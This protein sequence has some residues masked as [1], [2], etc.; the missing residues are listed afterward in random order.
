MILIK[1]VLATEYFRMP[2]LYRFDDY[3]KCFGLYESKALYCVVNSFIKPDGKSQLYKFID[4]FSSNRK[5]HLRHDKLQRGIC[6]NS[7]EEIVQ[8]L[9]RNAN[10]YFVEKFP[11]NSKVSESWKL[12]ENIS[13]FSI[14]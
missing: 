2:M 4:K 11:M 6:I 7:C 5:Q 13:L 12:Q 10:N 1:S 14:F 3:E 9:G 8:K